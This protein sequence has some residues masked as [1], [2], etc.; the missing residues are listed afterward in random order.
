MRDLIPNRLSAIICLAASNFAWVAAAQDAVQWGPASSPS[1]L[2]IGPTDAPGALAQVTFWN[3]NRHTTRH[4]GDVTWAD[5]QAGYLIEVDAGAPGD[6]GRAD[7][8]TITVPDGLIV[9]PPEAE[10]HEGATQV[11]LI[12]P[13]E[14]V[15]M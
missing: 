11:F 9:E 5:V 3:Q 7:R 13:L 12:Y 6:L 10:V 4:E 15:G 1:T 8:V 2:Q 14:G